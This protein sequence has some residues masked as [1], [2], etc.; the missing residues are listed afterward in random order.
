[1]KRGI[2]LL[3]VLSLI[4]V[5]LSQS[6]DLNTFQ[7]GFNTQCNS[8]GRP[9]CVRT[10]GNPFSTNPTY[11]CVECLSNCDCKLNYFCSKQ[12]GQIG[13]CKKFDLNGKSC[14][15]LN[16][17]QILNQTW[18]A[19]WKCAM[20]FTDYNNTVG[21]DQAGSCIESKCRYC[22]YNGNGG[23]SSCGVSDGVQKERTC[24]YPGT[25]VT[26]YGIQWVPSAYYENPRNV[27]WAIFF[28]LLMIVMVIQTITFYGKM[29][30]KGKKKN[31]SNESTHATE[32]QLGNTSKH[33]T[34][35]QGHSTISPTAN[36]SSTPPPYSGA[37]SKHNTSPPP[38]GS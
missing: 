12:F 19:S 38:Y 17:D 1:M 4:E 36:S 35:N 20:F 24:V 33:G 25:Q 8:K 13:T 26:S 7:S 29:K 16:Q 27:W 18:P 28:C 34:S 6:C 37:E 3:L 23:L 30:G 9:Y 2:C 14:L 11:E 31:K 5:I 32:I 22:S 10:D 15:P 21:V